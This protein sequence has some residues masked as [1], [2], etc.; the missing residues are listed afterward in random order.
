MEGVAASVGGHETLLDIKENANDGNDAGIV[1]ANLDEFFGWVYEYYVEKGY[2]CMILSRITNLITLAFT[3]L[4][5]TFLM[6]FVN[7][8]ALLNCNTEETC[9]HVIG[10][11]PN[12]MEGPTVGEVWLTFYF[13]LFC[14][15]WLWNGLCFFR[16]L[17]HVKEVATF[18]HTR[19]RLE[20]EELATIE[21]DTVIKRIIQ[22]QDEIKLCRVR[23]LTELDITNRI[24]RTENYFLALFATNT[25]NFIGAFG[26]EEF[27]DS[28]TKEKKEDLFGFRETSLNKNNKE[29]E[30]E[31]EENKCLNKVVKKGFYK[32]FYSKT[33]D[34]NLRFCILNP[35]FDTSN[36]TIV[37]DAIGDIG[38]CNLRDRLLWMGILNL[39]ALPFIMIFMIIFFILRNAEEL[40]SSKRPLGPRQFT[41]LSQ[42]RLREF[43]ELPHYFQRRLSSCDEPAQAFINQFPSTYI[44][45]IAQSIAY[46][47]GAI[48]ALLLVLSLSDSFL[49]LSFRVFERNLL[50]YL[51]FFSILLGI[52][53]SL[54]PIKGITF[55]PRSAME[56]VAVHTHFFPAR[57]ITQCHRYKVLYEF[58]QMYK[59]RV[60]IFLNEIIGVFLVPYIL[61][62]PMRK[63]AGNIVDFIERVSVTTQG[64]GQLCAFATF[65]LEN[66]AD[67]SYFIKLPLETDVKIDEAISGKTHTYR[68]PREVDVLPYELRKDNKDDINTN[69]NKSRLHNYPLRA[70]HGKMEKSFINFA[71]NHPGWT[72]T[73]DACT[74][75]LS[76]IAYTINSQTNHKHSPPKKVRKNNIIKPKEEKESKEPYEH[77][78]DEDDEEDEDMLAFLKKQLVPTGK[79]ETHHHYKS[80]QSKSDQNDFCKPKQAFDLAHGLSWSQRCLFQS[81][82]NVASSI[83]QNENRP[84]NFKHNSVGRASQIDSSLYPLHEHN[85]NYNYMNDNVHTIND[86]QDEQDE[87]NNQYNQDEREQEEYEEDL[88]DTREE[89]NCGDLKGI[90]LDLALS[91]RHCKTCD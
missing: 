37:R 53:R 42:Y 7:W 21:W 80:S 44:G 62:G 11:R 25:L 63:A 2:W 83:V 16:A 18:Y 20:D 26:E 8:T 27:E 81:F 61:L 85:D 34:W 56:K 84:N 14:F 50:W 31:Q 35:L 64:M 68:P 5:S 91:I 23:H 3:I 72:T 77:K 87:Q 4:F 78:D 65:D 46:I 90:P 60:L 89:L 9:Q 36:F 76:K 75:Y 82:S 71:Q 38:E 51:A 6:G 52:S 12:I 70:D 54:I 55:K 10:L 32:G 57:W 69:N 19:L 88:E 47:S 79:S 45:I 30:Q 28:K 74:R 48:V 66:F 15:Y 49:L 33:L 58:S 43:G 17:S 22:S 41:L 40:H 13:I 1:E 39:I 29:Q 24:M 73:N 67:P 86:E 59:P